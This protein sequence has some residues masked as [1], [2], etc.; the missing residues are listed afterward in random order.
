MRD[1]GVIQLLTL[2]LLCPFSGSVLN[3]IQLKVMLLSATT[4]HY[5]G[6]LFS[7]QGFMFTEKFKL[8]HVQNET[9]VTGV[10]F[11]L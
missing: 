7:T 5:M 3:Q 11:G 4:V 1:C 10:I 2:A 6:V 9:V 8:I